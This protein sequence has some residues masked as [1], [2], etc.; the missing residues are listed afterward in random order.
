MRRRGRETVEL[1]EKEMREE[2][3]QGGRKKLVGEGKGDE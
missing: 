1:E 2:G 3:G